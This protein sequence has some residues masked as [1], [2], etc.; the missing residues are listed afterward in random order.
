MALYHFSL[1]T[2]EAKP[3]SKERYFFFY[4]ESTLCAWIV[5][6]KSGACTEI[7]ALAA[8]TRGT[9]K[10]KDLIYPE[11]T[12]EV[13]GHESDG[14]LVAYTG[15]GYLYYSCTDDKIR[16]RAETRRSTIAALDKLRIM[17]SVCLF[18]GMSRTDYI[19]WKGFELSR[20]E[21]ISEGQKG[22]E[23]FRES[24]LVAKAEDS[25]KA[26]STNEGWVAIG[27]SQITDRHELIKSYDN[28]L[29]SIETNNFIIS[30]YDGLSLSLIGW[31]RQ[32]VEEIRVNRSEDRLVTQDRETT[33]LQNMWLEDISRPYNRCAGRMPVWRDKVNPGMFCTWV[34][35]K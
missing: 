24:V 27:K 17:K 20:H 5:S 23:Y 33:I 26:T 16:T 31:N 2:V 29:F 12:V 19:R 32:H 8:D 6:L 14:R 35:D 22:E 3:G 11:S 7:K 28:D 15:N 34:H 4:S 30:Q 9:M 25:T 21:T 18:P 10:M 1:E 13:I